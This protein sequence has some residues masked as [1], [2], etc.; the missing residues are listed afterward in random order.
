M[1]IWRFEKYIPKIGKNTYIAESADVIGNVTIGNNCYIGPGARI[2]GDYGKIIIG[3]GCSIQENVVIHARPNGTT[4]IGNNVT[5]GHMALLH[6][7]TVDD[8]AVVGM[9][10][11]V[12]DFSHLKKWAVLGEGALAK[13]NFILEENKIAV[14][15]PAKII[16]DISDKKEI[17]DELMQYKEKY[18]EM[19]IRHL[20]D[21]ALEKIN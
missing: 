8:F 1:T 12:S 10:S 16:G 5:I 14:G 20:A 9:G 18:K 19:A 3:D 11:I 2:R 7:C 21:N 4:T 13:K 17:K 15:I 6:N